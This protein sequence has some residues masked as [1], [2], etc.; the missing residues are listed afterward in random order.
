MVMAS[1]ASLR[2]TE[3]EEAVFRCVASGEPKPN[4]RWTRLQGSFPKSSV[5]VKGVL[6]IYPATL[7]DG[8][9]YICT[10]ANRFGAVASTVTLKVDKGKLLVENGR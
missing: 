3:G 1:P 7:G 2:V 6:R 5:A 8:G 9:S 10:A 4:I